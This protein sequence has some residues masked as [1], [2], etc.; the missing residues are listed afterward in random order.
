MR[1]GEG[2]RLAL[3]RAR[4]KGRRVRRALL[5]EVDGASMQSPGAELYLAEDGEVIGAI[6]GGCADEAIVAALAVQPM[7]GAAGRLLRFRTDPDTSRID[8][9]PSGCA[10]VLTVL[11]EAAP[12]QDLLQARIAG[13]RY[14]RRGVRD[15]AA[16]SRI[17][18][19]RA[20]DGQPTPAS[21][22]MLCDHHLIEW[23][24]PATNLV[25]IGAGAVAMLVAQS[26]ALLDVT[27]TVCDPRAA[28]GCTPAPPGVRHLACWPDAA[29]AAAAIHSADAVCALAQHPRL[30]VAGL[31]A[32]LRAEVPFVGALGSAR[33]RAALRAEL[34]AA[35]V[36]E[37]LARR[38][39]VPLGARPGRTIP[40]L[41]L[42]I[43]TAIPLATC[44]AGRS[45]TP[46]SRR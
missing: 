35:G 3:A 37:P 45:P 12:P 39:R 43:L 7:Q 15:A 31:A 34:C 33:R 16:P 30:D 18:A 40:E 27:V 6:A 22:I 10:A 26:A 24:P 25:L 8:G 13:T 17:T 42:A 2:V 44:D 38:V 41:A 29:G 9:L 46:G 36:P 5:V 4:R 20:S 19:W 32:A 14:V 28:A 11:L 23:L 1:P 21:R